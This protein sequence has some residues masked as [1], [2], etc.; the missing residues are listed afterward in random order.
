LDTF[1][2][3]GLFVIGFEHIPA[4]ISLDPLLDSFE[5][6]ARQVM[7]IN[8]GDRIEQKREGLVHSEHQV[9]RCIGWQLNK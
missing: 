7:K 2:K 3:K 4:K 9:V 6:I 8:L 1:P 5:S